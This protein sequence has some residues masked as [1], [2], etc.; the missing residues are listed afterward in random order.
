[1]PQSTFAAIRWQAL[2]HPAAQAR[3]HVL[4][5]AFPR[6]RWAKPRLRT[7]RPRLKYPA[8][9]L[10]PFFLVSAAFAVS[11]VVHAATFEG[12][13]RLKM[14]APRGG[15]HD[16]TLHVKDGVQRADIDTGRGATVSAITD[17]S[18][19]EM[20]MLMPEQKM[21]MV[22]SLDKMAAAAGDMKDSS[23]ATFTKTGETEKI[24]GYT[25]TKYVATS[26]G[27]TSDIW[28]TEELG[29]FMGLGSGGNPLGG[30]SR[31]AQPAW[32]KAL[33]GRDFFP[34]RVVSHDA[35]GEQFRMEATAVDKAPQPDSLFTPP[36]DYKKFDLG[37]MMQ[38]L[39]FPGKR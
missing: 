12:A 6:C 25:C 1:M 37:G 17:V 27:F 35:K 7:A 23:D 21:Y 34:L 33:V 14:T 15:S 3:P 20:I 26:K 22:H 39:G 31:N 4:Q 18:K 8:M 10:A 28:A 38:G 32:E 13:I 2:N 19:H 24:L 30:K 5:S 9:K 11:A 29:R 16:I 36:A